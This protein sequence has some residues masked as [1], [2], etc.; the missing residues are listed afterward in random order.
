MS[1]S[2]TISPAGFSG[3]LVDL[4]Q[5]STRGLAAIKGAA[6]RVSSAVAITENLLATT[7]HTLKREERIG[8]VLPSGK[9][10]TA[11]LAGRAPG[12][13]VA[14][15][16]VEGGGLETLPAAAPARVGALVTVVGFTA[17]V[18]PSASL[19]MIGAVGAQRRTWRGGTLD[20]FLR[21]DV[22]LYPS[23][24]GAAVIDMQGGLVGLATPALLRHSAVAVPYATLQRVANEVQREGRIRQ[25]YLGVGLQTV[26]L[27]ENLQQRA[28]VESL[29]GLM[30]LSVEP[31]SPAENS[32]LQMGDILV[33]L[34][35]RITAEPEDLQDALRGDAVGQTREA[36]LIRGGEVV[37]VPVFIHERT[38]SKQKE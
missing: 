32:G 4:I 20:Q 34:G 1:S 33:S 3:Q 24:S 22:N 9:E 15:L 2:E 30:L 18:G 38:G 14:I 12:L 8:V 27:P 5:Q 16:R 35:G 29:S 23:Q 17:D 36:V 25:G 10:V 37:H 7:D 21:L 6:Y 13:D 19:G 11:T 31:G 26:A 28:G